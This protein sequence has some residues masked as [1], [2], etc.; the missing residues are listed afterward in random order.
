MPNP[1]LID[2]DYVQTA[3]FTLRTKDLKYLDKLARKFKNRSEA[4]RAILDEAQR[5]TK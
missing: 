3:S 1:R 2:N 4:L 5:K